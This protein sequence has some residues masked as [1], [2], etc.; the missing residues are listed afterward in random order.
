MEEVKKELVEKMA[1]LKP[2]DLILAQNTIDVL[3]ARDK[4]E[5]S[6]KQLVQQ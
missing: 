1:K 2:I 4:I 5:T 6:K 3:L